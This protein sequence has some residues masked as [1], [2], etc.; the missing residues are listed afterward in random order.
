MFICHNLQYQVWLKLCQDLS[1]PALLS[2][3]LVPADG[4]RGFL[5]C[6]RCVP[7]KAEFFLP[8]VTKCLLTVG[9]VGFVFVVS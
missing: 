3:Q 6:L 1:L 2:P 8:T 9:T 7:V 5:V 4:L